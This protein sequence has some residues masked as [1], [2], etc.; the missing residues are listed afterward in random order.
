MT[1]SALDDLLLR[2]A[3]GFSFLYPAIDGVIHPDAWISFFPPFVLTLVPGIIALY[4]W[5]LVEAVIALWIFSGR[6]IFLPSLAATAA[7]VLIV[8][9]N[10]SLMEIVFRD[11]G[12]AC[13]AAALVIRSSKRAAAV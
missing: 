8:V 7:L 10:L 13:A 12:L 9:F 1:R 6:N 4:A 5:C 11:I 2:T 3:V